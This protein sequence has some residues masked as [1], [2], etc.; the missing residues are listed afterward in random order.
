MAHL[1]LQGHHGA[2]PHQV[3]EDQVVVE[4]ERGAR[5]LLRFRPTFP[6]TV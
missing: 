2:H 4:M 3:A 1:C 5:L 6:E